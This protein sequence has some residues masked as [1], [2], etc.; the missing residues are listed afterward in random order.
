MAICIIP[1]M[2]AKESGCAKEQGLDA[3]IYLCIGDYGFLRI[4]AE[5]DVV[6]LRITRDIPMTAAFQALAGV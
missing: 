4:I 3:P 2:G 1:T 6:V 5:Y